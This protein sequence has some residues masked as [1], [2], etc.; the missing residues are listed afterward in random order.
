MSGRLQL[1][2]DDMLISPVPTSGPSVE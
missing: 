2:D 1:I